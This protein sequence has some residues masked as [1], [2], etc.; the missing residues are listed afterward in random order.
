M[1]ILRSVFLG[2]ALLV[3]MGSPIQAEAREGVEAFDLGQVIVTA[4][5]TEHRLGD[6]PVAASV[7]TREEI[8]AKNIK[9]VQDALIYLTGVRMLR[10]PGSWGAE[11]LVQIQGLHSRHT[12]ILVDG[13]RVFGGST[14]RVDVNQI[15]IA[16]VERIEVVRGPGSA[17]HGSGAMGGVI[18]IITRPAPEE[19]TA[20]ISTAF[21]SRATQVHEVVAGFR[22]GE[23]GQWGATFNLT[24]RGTEGVRGEFTDVDWRGRVIHGSDESMIRIFQ[25]SLE[26]EFSP[27]SK[28]TLSPLHSEQIT[29]DTVRAPATETLDRTQVRQGL[30]AAWEWQPDELS[31]LNVRGS[32]FDYERRADSITHSDEDLISREAEVT[33]SRLLGRH[34]LTAGYHYQY[35]TIERHGG[36][37]VFDAYQTTHS[38]LLQ[39]EIDLDPLTLVLG[40]RLDYHDA[41]GAEVN[42]Q[43]SLL[44]RVTEAL[45]LRA[46]A[47]TAFKGPRL[48]HLYSDWWHGAMFFAHANPDLKP[49]E[50][51]GYQLGVEYQFSPRM[52]GK[53]SLFRNEIENMVVHRLDR[54]VRPWSLFWEN[55]AEATT[56]GVELSLAG[57]LMNHLT[58][59]FGYT[60]LSTEDE[61]TGLE[62][63]GRP[64]NMLTLELNQ[65]IPVLN[66]NLN[67]AGRHTGRRYRDRANTVRRPGY[68]VFDLALT[69]DFRE[70]EVFARVDNVLGE[71]EIGDEVGLDG[72]EFLVGLRMNF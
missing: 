63:T 66:L 56:Q 26:H 70:H 35:H 34:A 42:P 64:R 13:Q 45:R 25:G 59:R 71:E 67:L 7:I 52:L 48:M 20:S 24:Y 61:A 54:T 18:N 2:G 23:W 9:T 27:E 62:L 58:A 33:Y 50:S 32:W 49:E 72:T 8:E 57:Q 12:L 29:Q 47:G 38:F 15:S 3:V 53:L 10:T 51:I 19:L 36:W 21:G 41:W 14:D 16:M 37:V 44:Y 17:L 68:T 22:G 30:N 65:E 46:S 60:L 39:N 6:V 5:R 40:A 1:R 55:V 31:V 69:Y 4:T 43:A 28:L 11:G